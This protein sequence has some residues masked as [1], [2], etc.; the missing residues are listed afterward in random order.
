MI[1]GYAALIAETTPEPDERH[2]HA[3]EIARASRRGAELTTRLLAFA[4][5]QVPAAR[6]LDLREV[7]WE[8]ARALDLLVPDDVVL[9]VDAGDEPVI[10]HGD[11][12]RLG[13]V[14]VN[15]VT[16]AV[17]AIQGDGRSSFAWT[18]AGRRSARGRG[19]GQRDREDALPLV[20]EPF[21]TTR[22]QGR[23][24]GLSAAHTAI[25]EA[26]GGSR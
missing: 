20:F 8:L 4:P 19:Y 3:L 12:G 21:F 9:T 5:Q 15:L 1:D 18:R 14:I 22:E 25:S 10:V 24:L 13:H 17:D 23:G 6:D 2:A 26:E 16:N 11:A 7:V